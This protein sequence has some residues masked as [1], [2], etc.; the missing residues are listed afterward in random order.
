MVNSV[1]ASAPFTPAL[2]GVAARQLDPNNARPHRTDHAIGDLVQLSTSSQSE[3]LQQRNRLDVA[4]GR[5]EIA[6]IAARDVLGVL[7]QISD[8][9]SRN[10]DPNVPP[11][12]RALQQGSLEG[13]LSRLEQIVTRA[14]EAGGDLIAGGTLTIEGQVAGLT[15]EIDGVDLRLSATPGS[16]AALQLT[17]GHNVNDAAS[18][19]RTARASQGSLAAVSQALT[20][21]DAAAERLARHDTVLGALDSALASQVRPDL[22]ADGARLLAL[23]VRQGLAGT[24]FNISQ[25]APKALLS[26]FRETS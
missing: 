15:I 13:F 9:A 16:D 19:A 23:Q 5:L 3:V 1:G 22:D 10:A 25:Q 14:L 4:Q 12:A 6:V 7:G 26:L 8:L 21:L 17:L 11:E 20:R 18:A 24:D 2:A